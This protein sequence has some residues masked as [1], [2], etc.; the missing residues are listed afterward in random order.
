MGREIPSHA[1]LLLYGL[2]LVGR[3]GMRMSE[4]PPPIIIDI[5]PSGWEESYRVLEKSTRNV[6]RMFLFEL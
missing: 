6:L 4:V 3:V 5:H 2:L 1:P